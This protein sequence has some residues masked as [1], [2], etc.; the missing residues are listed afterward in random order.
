LAAKIDGCNQFQVFRRIVL[1][2][3]RPVLAVCVVFTCL[4]NW[5]DLMG[6]LIYLLRN[7][8]FTV[9][10]GLANMVTRQDPHLNT[11]MAANLVMM[12]PPVILYF[13]AQDKLVGGIA[14]VA[15]KG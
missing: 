15:I 14:S 13:F 9:A 10:I 11:L 7:E 5:N 6:P 3:I 8:D 12:I 4:D 2:L 1:P